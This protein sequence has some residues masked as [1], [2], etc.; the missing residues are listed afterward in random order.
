MFIFDSCVL[1]IYIHL[2]IGG[3]F[4]SRVAPSFLFKTMFSLVLKI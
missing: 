2:V 3:F 4:E 1:K